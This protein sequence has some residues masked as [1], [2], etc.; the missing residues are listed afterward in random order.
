MKKNILLLLTIAILSTIVPIGMSEAYASEKKVE[1]LLSK[2][3][4]NKGYVKPRSK[5]I[6]GIFKR[7]SNCGCPNK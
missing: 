3:K 2:K 6:L 4:R 5:K 7:K 1:T